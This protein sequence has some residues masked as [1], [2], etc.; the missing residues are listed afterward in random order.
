MPGAVNRVTIG[1]VWARASSGGATGSFNLLKEASDKATTLYKNNFTLKVGPEAPKLEIVELDRK[2]IIKLLNTKSIE[3]FTDT[4]AG[5]CPQPTIYKFQG[6]QVWQLKTASIPS[7]IND[8]SQ[9]RLVAQ[10]D[11]IDG[12][13]RVVNT[14]FSP[15]LEESVKRIM[16]EGTNKGIQH[17]FEITKDLFETGSDQSLVNFKNYNY[18]V[19][20]YATASAACPTDADQYLSSSKTIGEA[21]LSIYTALPHDP[22]P[23]G[24]SINSDYGTGLPITMG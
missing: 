5:P 11:I 24:K 3:R 6:Y 1:V 20:S 9:A 10:F 13:A 18:Y 4:F 7:D 15:E 21:S 12:V 8:P 2:L 14:V 22:T 19:V 17:S 23:S 16:V